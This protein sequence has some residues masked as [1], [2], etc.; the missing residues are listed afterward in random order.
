[1]ALQNRQ[2]EFCMAKYK[3]DREFLSAFLQ[4]GN[5]CLSRELSYVFVIPLSAWWT[6]SEEVVTLLSYCVS[7]CDVI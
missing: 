2:P 1:M 5:S 4:D 6:K 7:M 3:N